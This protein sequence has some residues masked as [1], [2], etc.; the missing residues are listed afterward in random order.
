MFVSVR[1]TVATIGRA[2]ANAWAVVVNSW[3]RIR[4]RG[5]NSRA[6]NN[7]RRLYVFGSIGRQQFDEGVQTL[8]RPG[9]RRKQSSGDRRSR[10]AG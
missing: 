6:L 2:V 4:G 9:R 3:R 5:Q 7:L 8:D 10:R 1:K